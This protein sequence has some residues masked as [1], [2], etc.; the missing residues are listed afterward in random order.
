MTPKM[1]LLTTYPLRHT[2]LLVANVH[3]LN[4]QP[5]FTYML[6][7]QL[8]QIKEHVS[9]HE[10]P[11]IVCG[12]FNTWREDRLAMV[13]T[14]FNDFEAV[15]FSP[16]ARS[17]GVCLPGSQVT[18]HWRWTTCLS[19]GWRSSIRRF[20]CSSRPIIDRWSYI[21]VSTINPRGFL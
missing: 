1:S 6:S 12:D 5:V 3:A 4:F 8:G 13:R 2:E 14:M 21:C 16:D 15:M 20:C 11:V 17:R 10:G 9:A 19:K 7:S 18:P